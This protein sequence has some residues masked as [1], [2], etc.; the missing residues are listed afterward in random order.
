MAH[1]TIIDGGYR[2]VTVVRGP[3]PIMDVALIE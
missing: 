3:D 1:V 2:G